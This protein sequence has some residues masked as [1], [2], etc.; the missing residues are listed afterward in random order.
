MSIQIGQDVIRQDEAQQALSSNYLAPAS[1]LDPEHKQWSPCHQQKPS[2]TPSALEPK[3]RYT[4]GTSSWKPWTPSASTCA[5]IPTAQQASLWHQDRE[6]Q[7]EQNTSNSNSCSSKISS[8][9]VWYH[10]TRYQPKTTQQTSSQNTWQQKC[11]DGSSTAQ[12]STPTEEKLQQVSPV[13][14]VCNKHTS[15]YKHRADWLSHGR[16]QTSAA[17]QVWLLQ[18]SVP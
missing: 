13:S 12:A 7:N 1:I 2:F 10:S 16:M 15:A 8:K 11:W 5:S 6:Y 3:K 9:E 14:P 4:S 17:H 18:L